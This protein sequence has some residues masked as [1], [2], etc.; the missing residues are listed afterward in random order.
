MSQRF[1]ITDAVRVVHVASNL[2]LWEFH[3]KPRVN[4]VAGK[5]SRCVGE[6]IV[7]SNA[8]HSPQVH[9]VQTNR[10]ASHACLHMARSF[11]KNKRRSVCITCSSASSVNISRPP[12]AKRETPRRIWYSFSKHG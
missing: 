9:T 8:A 12:P 2:D 7:R 6:K 1:R 11:A 4:Y 5:A 3:S 10:S